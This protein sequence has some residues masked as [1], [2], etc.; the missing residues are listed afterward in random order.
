[1]TDALKRVPLTLL[2]I[3]YGVYVLVVFLTFGLSAFVAVLLPLGIKA[4]RHIAHFAGRAFFAVA[5][6]RLRVIDEQL[7]PTG[8]CVVVANHASYL[9]GIVLKA[10]LP[11]RFSFVI[12]K[13]FSRVPLAGLLLRRIGS[14]F[15]DRF[16][17]HAG[18]MDARRLLKAAD[19]GQALAFFPEGTF[20]AEPG[21]G[22]F[23]S[24]AF[25]I[26]ARVDLPVVPLVIK[27]TRS[28]L[29]SGRFLP[30]PGRIDIQVLP[31]IGPMRDMKSS[32]AVAHT[33]DLAHARILAELG[34]PDLSST[35][36]IAAL[37]SRRS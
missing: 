31:S 14:E 23:H 37:Q 3:V 21:L 20:L 22:K 1:M 17:R 6:L 15:V 4:R 8:P 2:E 30:R 29:P 33:R 24:G 7:L 16:N 10:A 9:D 26:A 32:E 25:T 28:I 18:G 35:D 34:E 12:K 13:E 5:G 19:A 36:G 11:A 27:G